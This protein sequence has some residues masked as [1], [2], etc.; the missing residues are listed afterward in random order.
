LNN[1][2]RHADAHNVHIAVDYGDHAVQVQVSD[3]GRGFDVE[4]LRQSATFGRQPLG[5]AGMQERAALLGG[6]V[7]I[8]SRPG[9]GTLIEAS[10]PY[11]EESEEGR[12]HATAVGG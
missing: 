7:T 8:R 2:I 4:R 11:R 10:L 9:D 1:V 5:L 12:E 3:D 6:R